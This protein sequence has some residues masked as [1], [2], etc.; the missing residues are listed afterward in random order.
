MKF[1]IGSVF[2]LAC[3]LAGGVES[4]IGTTRGSHQV[5]QV[6]ERAVYDD[7]DSFAL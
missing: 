7:H 2:F 4:S 1:S 3:L 5:R 6:V